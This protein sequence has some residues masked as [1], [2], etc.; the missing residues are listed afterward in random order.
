MRFKWLL[1]VEVVI[2]FVF[3]PVPFLYLEATDLRWY[4]NTS[5]SEIYHLDSEHQSFFVRKVIFRLEVA[6]IRELD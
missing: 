1:V 4:L 5:S 6:A 2:I 3:A